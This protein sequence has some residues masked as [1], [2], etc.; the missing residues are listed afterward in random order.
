MALF[1]VVRRENEFRQPAARLIVG[2]GN[3]GP[4]YRNTRHNAGFL[5][6]EEFVTAHNLSPF[7]YKADLHANVSE[8]T[9][10]DAK[11][12]IAEPTTLM[13]LSGKA[14]FHLQQYFN[15]GTDQILIVYDDI[16]VAFG[17]VRA[18]LSGSDG[19]HNG[20]KSVTNTIG[21]H[22]ARLR[23]GVSNDQRE[24]IQAKDFVLGRFYKHE[25]NQ[26]PAIWQATNSYIDT[27]IRGEYANDSTSI[28]LA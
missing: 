3:V 16:D 6:V 24:T 2:L 28:A 21:E 27:F 4:E 19:G 23:I 25:R 8:S 20:L 22:Y 12:I 1:T 14:V 9:L 10:H 5:A 17:T 7:T 15:L 26:L 13:N 11:V 18:R